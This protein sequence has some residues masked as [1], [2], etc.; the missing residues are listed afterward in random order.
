MV[1]LMFVLAMVILADL[2]HC[3]EQ[4]NDIECADLMTFVPATSLCMTVVG[5]VIYT[6][7]GFFLAE[8]RVRNS[9]GASTNRAVDHPDRM[10]VFQK[11]SS[12]R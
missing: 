5:G 6:F 4:L 10:N 12:S 9:P 11:Y 8:W 3:Y 2:Y 7:L 1:G